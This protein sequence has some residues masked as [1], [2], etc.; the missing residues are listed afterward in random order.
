[1]RAVQVIMESVTKL[2]RMITNPKEVGPEMGWVPIG[3][4]ITDFLTKTTLFIGT[5][6]R[7]NQTRGCLACLVQ[8][9]LALAFLLNLTVNPHNKF[10]HIENISIYS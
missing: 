8:R 3:L 5:H 4:L 6:D 1:M 7:G 9:I 2:V 10:P